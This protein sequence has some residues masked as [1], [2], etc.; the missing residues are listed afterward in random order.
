MLQFFRCTFVLLCLFLFSAQGAVNLSGSLSANT[1][2]NDGDT[3]FISDTLKV[4]TGITLTVNGGAVVKTAGNKP[5]V[6]NGTLN[7][8]GAEDSFA[9]FIPSSSSYWGG[10]IIESDGSASITG[11]FIDSAYYGIWNKS[12]NISVIECEIRKSDRYG[13][14]S[15]GNILIDQCKIYKN[16]YAAIYFISSEDKLTLTN[17]LVYDNN[18]ISG[19]K[20]S[21]VYVDGEIYI[22]NCTFDN[23]GDDAI[24]L[25]TSCQTDTIINCIMTDH[26]YS[27]NCNTSHLDS[28]PNC[29]NNNS[30]T[31]S[32]DNYRN[33]ID[34]GGISIKPLFSSGY[35][36][37]HRSPSRGSGFNGSH[38]GAYPWS[39]ELTA[40]NLGYIWEDTAFADTQ[41]VSGD[42]TI[43]KGVTVTIDPGTVFLFSKDWDGMSSGEVTDKCEFKIHGNVITN[44]T[45]ENPLIFKSKGQKINGEYVTYAGDWNGIQ[46]LNDAVEINNALISDAEYGISNNSRNV[47][48]WDVEIFK[49][50]R[51]GIYSNGNLTVDRSQIYNN[52]S[53]GIEFDSPSDKLTLINSLIFGNDVGSGVTTKGV[54]VTGILYA[55]NNT[56]TDNDHYGIYKPLS[57]SADTITNNILTDHRFYGFYG[58]GA[59]SE[60]LPVSINNNAWNNGHGNLKDVTSIGDLSTDPLFVNGVFKI[61]QLQPN[62]PC[63]DAG[64]NISSINTDIEGNSRPLLGKSEGSPAFDIGCYEYDPSINKFPIV[65][66]GSDTAVLENE[67]VTFDGTQSYD[68]DGSIVE[69]Y[70]E[71]DNT[72]TSTDQNPSHTYPSAGTTYNILLRVTDNG[73]LINYGSK[74]LYVNRKP[75]AV[76]GNDTTI[77]YGNELLFDASGSYDYYGR[78]KN[79]KW[80][81]GDGDSSSLK[82]VNHLY[83][84]AGNYT[85]IL[86]VTDTFN[87]EDRDTLE[88]TV[89]DNGSIAPVIYKTSHDTTIYKNDSLCLFV[90]Y[91]GE[92]PIS[93][94]W[95]KNGADIPGEDSSSL[96]ISKAI[97][98][99]SG[100]YRCIVSN[101]LGADTSEVVVL[102]VENRTPTISKVDTMFIT[103]DTFTKVLL[104]NSDAI[105]LDGDSL[106]FVFRDGNNYSFSNDT[107]FPDENYNGELIVPVQVS[108]GISISSIVNVIV[109]IEAVNDAPFISGSLTDTAV[110]AGENIEYVI[111]LDLFTD[112]DIDDS[113][114]ISVTG[115]PAGFS[116]HDNIIS[117]SSIISGEFS[118]AVQGMDNF[119]EEV[120][121]TFLLTI[122]PQTE[123]KEVSI[124]SIGNINGLIAMPNFVKYN[125]KFVELHVNENLSGRGSISVFDALGDN[126]DHQKIN[127][128]KGGRFKWDL[129]NRDGI[130]VTSGIYIASLNLKLENGSSYKSKTKIAVQLD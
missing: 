87:I 3:A 106:F 30:L 7:V 58:G 35:Q 32:S 10:L 126:I 120:S 77:D 104:S 50:K 92:D 110:G 95:Q 62:S 109:N 71:L 23:N 63:V 13:I 11:A 118:I 44:G 103:E 15:E 75:N 70:W 27:V 39:G 83:K 6:I 47:K 117:G 78:I 89:T 64:V 127:I 98:S 29:I 108:D 128:K 54:N 25:L 20:K 100:N 14:F 2:L 38:Q 102:K 68:P 46:I 115:L 24:Y 69:Y 76:A 116:F 53:G 72:T 59:N 119:S 1:E 107:I 45:K 129:K 125:D 61:F 81:F 121:D 16:D 85:A 31:Y 33:V 42:L 74:K 22:S 41:I 101:S 67:L 60:T 66:I 8:N 86:I 52:W 79:W 90:A 113:I 123:I 28:L 36:L 51:Y 111:P 9:Y 73:G 55:A 26:K 82:E 93:L 122:W 124:K 84:E 114:K 48:I 18:G 96:I 40:S 5:I 57:T 91:I 17:S 130:P 88:V 56:I 112:I 34:S 43:V 19:F 65:N 94:Q 37:T 12:D 21:G 105:D 4:P 97:L 99:D 49:C 80:Y